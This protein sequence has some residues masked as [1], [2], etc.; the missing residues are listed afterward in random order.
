M[1][2]TMRRAAVGTAVMLAIAAAAIAPAASGQGSAI[3]E[4]EKYRAALQDG[5]PAELWEIRG[6]DLWKQPRRSEE[7][8]VREVRP[9]P[10]RRRG[11]GRVREA[12]ALLR[13]RR[14]R[15]GPRDAPGPL[16]GQRC[17]A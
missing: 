16:H 13:R 10:G 2:S 12:A 15:D 3:E 1:H 11:Q 17:R 5:N 6:E 9:R 7:G 4:I 8:L 14:P